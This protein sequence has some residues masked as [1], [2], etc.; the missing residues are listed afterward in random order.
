MYFPFAV[1]I[2]EVDVNSLNVSQITALMSKRSDRERRLT[3]VTSSKT[4]SRVAPQ[5]SVTTFE[6]NASPV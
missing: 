1:A 3:V 5:G 4:S 2:D 6:S